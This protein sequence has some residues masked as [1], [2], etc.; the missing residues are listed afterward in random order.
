MYNLLERIFLDAAEKDYL[1]TQLLITNIEEQYDD[2]DDFI[3]KSICHILNWHH[4]ANARLL[5]RKPDSDLWDLLPVMYWNR[6]HDQNYF[7]TKNLIEVFFIDEMLNEEKVII[8]HN[9]LINLFEHSIYHRSQ[10]IFYLKQNDLKI[11]NFQMIM[12]Q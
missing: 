4:I 7:Q 10:L 5:S 1:K 9:H 3:K 2:I 8:F 12:I 11:P 6:L